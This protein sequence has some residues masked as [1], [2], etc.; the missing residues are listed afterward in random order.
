MQYYDIKQIKYI[1]VD[2]NFKLIVYI[3]RFST[4]FV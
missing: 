3:S 4:A 1:T 2:A